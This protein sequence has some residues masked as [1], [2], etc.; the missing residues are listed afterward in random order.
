MI[1][2]VLAQP[3]WPRAAESQPAPL[4]L[5]VDDSL[6]VRKVVE[7]TLRRA[8]FDVLSFADGVTALR[9]LRGPEAVM[10]ALIYLDI[11]LPRMDGYEVARVLRGLPGLE[12][13]AII[14]L[15]ARAGL[16][17]C[18]KSRLVGAQNHL[19]KPFKVEQLVALTREALA[20]FFQAARAG[21]EEQA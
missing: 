14:M 20:T 2:S 15:S 21:E 17:D 4:I 8:G 6:T 7:V 16:L 12:H 18:L 19:G 10:P 1:Q 9:W 13:T 5:V 11:G 3:V